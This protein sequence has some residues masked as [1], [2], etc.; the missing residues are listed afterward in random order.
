MAIDREAQAR[1]DA[2]RVFDALHPGIVGN[3]FIPHWPTPPQAYFLGLHIHLQSP[4]DQVFEALFGGA[5]GGGKSDALLMGAAQYAWQHS[6]FAGVCVRR[7]YAELAQPDALMD[8]AM[9]W[10]LPAGVHWNGTDKLF[11][12]P[13]GAR[14]KMAYH[15][16]PRD[17][18]QFQGA[19]YQYA[20]WDELTHW[21]DA[22]AYE[23]VSLS[24]LRRPEGSKIPLRA[25]SATNPG[26][27][28]HSWV[29]DRFVG[30]QRVDGVLIEPEC[31]YV[32][33][34]VTDNPHLDSKAYVQ[35]L[36]RL[37][38]TV[39]K[40]LLDGD[41]TAREPG[42]YFRAEWFGPLLEPEEYPVPS[43]DS[44]RIRWWDLAASE[45]QG[46]ARTA[47][48][49]MARM[50]S[51]VRV[52]LHA[53]AFRATPG[54]RDDLIVQQAKIDGRATVVGV[55]IEGGSG[56]PAQFEALRKRLGSQGFKVVG[57]RPRVLTE[58][59]SLTVIR[60]PMSTTGKAGRADPVASCLERG[61]QRRG[62]CLDTGGPWWG[63]DSD[64]G[65]LDARDGIRLMAGPWVQEY[66]DE[67]EGFPDSPTVD[68]V[69]ATSG[70]WAWL[71]A[72]P[73]GKAAPPRV[74]QAAQAGELQNI[75]PDARAKPKRSSS[76]TA[77]RRGRWD[78]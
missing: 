18:L 42:D 58:D 69:D 31:P 30:G 14:V 74:M 23:W 65:P 29:R 25:L 46:S 34:R 1:E 41:W 6:E 49:L 35:S 33:A 38:P 10:W 22:R 13:S 66:L 48:V 36:S 55:E 8:R 50:R 2:L 61:W 63:E 67:L 26:V 75:H 24:R 3:P 16:H 51:G 9:K 7:S 62:E 43:G 53:T 76:P 78:P 59:E 72:H 64:R 45:R 17:D 40:Q 47:G 19:A 77:P 71:E 21:P 20:G 44:I 52:V 57:A 73:F 28:G 12:F 27:P 5:A 56:G 11:T 70:A 15:G 68:L 39:R 54:K 60:N 32:P 4:E 37:H